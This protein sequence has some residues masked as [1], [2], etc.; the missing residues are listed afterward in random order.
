MKIMKLRCRIPVELIS[1][2]AISKKNIS[3]IYKYN[4]LITYIIPIHSRTTTNEI[5]IE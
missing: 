2:F 4:Y 5:C 3:L 1:T